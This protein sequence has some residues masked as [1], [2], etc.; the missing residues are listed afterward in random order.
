MIRLD[1]MGLPEMRW[2]IP[3]ASEKLTLEKL[4]IGSSILELAAL[5]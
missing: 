2:Y 4:K 5:K 3:R 1:G